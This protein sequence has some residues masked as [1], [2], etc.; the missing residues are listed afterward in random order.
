MAKMGKNSEFC[1]R[2]EAAAHIKLANELK[3][4]LKKF[5]LISRPRFFFISRNSILPRS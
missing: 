3:F 2:P 5:K 4:D 1:A